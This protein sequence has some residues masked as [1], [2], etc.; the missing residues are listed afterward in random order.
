MP[1]SGVAALVRFVYLDEAGTSAK[2]PVTVVAGIIV[3]A[4]TQW[5]PAEADVN[6]IVKD[7][8]PERYKENFVFHATEIWGSRKFRDGWDRNDRT[9]FLKEMMSVPH[10][11]EHP[12]RCGED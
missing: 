12:P 3:H 5:R 8:V 2:E 7:M 9:A 11:P 6:R 4:D 10:R 1:R